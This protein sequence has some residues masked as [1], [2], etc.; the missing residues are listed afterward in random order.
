MVLAALT[1]LYCNLLYCTVIGDKVPTSA[2]AS[3]LQY[4]QRHVLIKWVKRLAPGLWS[5]LESVLCFVGTTDRWC[6]LSRKEH[7]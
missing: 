5:T 6:S 3:E 7:T 2:L 4:G 1:I